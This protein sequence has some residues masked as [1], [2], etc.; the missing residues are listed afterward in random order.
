MLLW[1]AFAE[2]FQ[3]FSQC[4]LG[5]PRLRGTERAIRMIKESTERRKSFIKLYVVAESFDNHGTEK[6]A[7]GEQSP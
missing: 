5:S 1:V 2:V 3:E 7:G 4:A 6:A